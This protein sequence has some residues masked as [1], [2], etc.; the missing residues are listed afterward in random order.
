MNAAQRRCRARPRPSRDRWFAR[1]SRGRPAAPSSCRARTP[2]GAPPPASWPQARPCACPS[3]TRAYADHAS[4]RR[5]SSGRT[6][7]GRPADRR[8]RGAGR[9]RSWRWAVASSSSCRARE[10]AS[11]TCSEGWLLATLLEA[12]VV[13]GADTGDG[14]QLLPAQARDPPSPQVRDAHVLRLHP[15]TPGA[16][17]LADPV[18]AVHHID[19]TQSGLR[20]GGR[21]TPRLVVPRRTGALAKRARGVQGAW[22]DIDSPR[23]QQRLPSP[24]RPRGRSHRRHQRHRRSHRATG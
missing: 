16:Q 4:M 20:P 14:G 3:R 11:T 12:D 18:L 5:C 17:E 2:R 22:H 8:R 23:H 24:L 15:L 6:R 10:S 7:S 19:G 1:P 9:A 21:G 13:V